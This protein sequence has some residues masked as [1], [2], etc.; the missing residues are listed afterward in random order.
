MMLASRLPGILPPMSA[1]ESLEV[2]RV[3]SVAGLLGR[4]SCRNAH[5]ALL[6]ITFRWPVWSVAV[7]AWHDPA[8]PAWLTTAVCYF[9]PGRACIR[10]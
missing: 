3:Y 6:T 5:S 4:A 1:E 2:T 10:R 8:R 9:T 7:P